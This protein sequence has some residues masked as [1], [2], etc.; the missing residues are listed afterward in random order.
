MQHIRKTAFILLTVL[1][2]TVP[3][4]SHAAGAPS[5]TIISPIDGSSVDRKGKTEVRVEFKN[6]DRPMV[7]SGTAALRPLDLDGST[8]GYVIS[9]G[10]GGTVNTGQ[11]SGNYIIDWGL[12][13]MVPG[14]YSIVVQLSECAPQGCNWAPSGP[15][16]TKPKNPIWINVT[17]PSSTK[18]AKIVVTSPKEGKTYTAGSNQ[19]ILVGW[20]LESVPKGSKACLELLHHEPFIIS[21][22]PSEKENCQKAKKG[23][24]TFKGLPLSRSAYGVTLGEYVARV[25]IYGPK[26]KGEGVKIIAEQDSGPFT[27][28]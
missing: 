23:K 5:M 10:F 1:A 4:F 27:I 26:K 8:I 12:N 3:S 28:E 25:T 21:K 9:T 16:I 2:F 7:I 18:Y 15:G 6:I 22:F 20:K 17:D 14:K 13:D 24:N 11:K 19:K